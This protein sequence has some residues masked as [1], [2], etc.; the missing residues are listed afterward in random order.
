V[1][2]LGKFDHG[3][4]LRCEV[5]DV[6]GHGEI[7]RIC[8]SFPKAVSS[9]RLIAVYD[10]DS[11]DAIEDDI[12]W[13]AEFL[14]GDEAP[15]LLFRRAAEENLAQLAQLLGRDSDNL[16]V[17]LAQIQGLDHHDWLEDFIKLLQISYLE[18]MHARLE[19]W[20]GDLWNRAQAE[21]FIFDLQRSVKALE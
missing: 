8:G 10:G 9:F 2:L 18:G 16:D 5:V 4:L 7:T 13:P 20:L 15:E 6:G 21:N 1:R 11:W 3:L 14:P 17:I 19:V 12:D